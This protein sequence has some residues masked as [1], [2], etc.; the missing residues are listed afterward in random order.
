M[1]HRLEAWVTKRTTVETP[2]GHPAEPRL[3]LAGSDAKA[4]V[5]VLP[6]VI[7]A[8]ESLLQHAP[9]IYRWR[10]GRASSDGERWSALRAS[11]PY[12]WQHLTN[13]AYCLALA[14]WNEDEAGSAQF[15]EALVRWPKTLHQLAGGAEFRR[16]RYLFS[17]VMGLSWPEASA[18]VAPLTFEHMP[19]STPEQLFTVVVRGA[20][21][22]VLLL[23][24]GLLLFWTISDKQASDIGARTAMA[25][26][27]RMGGDDDR[28]GPLARGLSLRS[29]F[30][31]L[32]V[33]FEIA[34][35]R[36]SDGSYGAVLDRLVEVLDNM[37]ERRVVPGRVCTPSTLHGRDG[38]LLSF[39]AILACAVPDTGDDDLQ[40]TITALAAEEGILPGG[41]SALRNTLHELRHVSSSLEQP[42]PQLM[43]GIAMLA[44]G[45]DGTR[46]VARLGE[47]VNSAEATIEAARLQRLRDRP[48]DPAALDRI[49]L[50]VEAALLA[51]PAQVSFFEGVRIERSPR[52]DT[53]E[54]HEVAVEGVAKAQLVDPPMETPASGFEELLASRTRE[55][56][57]LRAWGAFTRR[58]RIQRNVGAKVEQEEFWREIAPLVEQV[59]PAPVLVISQNAEAR[60]LRRLV[61]EVAE[62]R[63]QLQ[64]ERR[65]RAERLG[66]YVATVAGV[67]VY[68]A[69]FPAGVAWLFSG[70]ALRSIRYSEFKASGDFVAIG[71]EPDVEL[72]GTLRLRFR[73][74]LE[75][76]LDPIFE[77]R[78]PDPDEEDDP[79]T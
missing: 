23:T 58:A 15:R 3:A 64:I 47:I 6:E 36:F 69:N 31:D 38:L 67:D 18:C 57:G 62:R 28:I 33:R 72:Q 5:N 14:V 44:P 60:A 8:W 54:W 26:L 39:V 49:R 16:R 21:D 68:G 56:A 70:R 63:P 50:A 59:G 4:Y 11:W 65:P 2:V 30:L 51:E 45:R 9:S 43:R 79:A 7:G 22:D 76:T 46:L 25:I 35:E 53:A 74:H 32:L 61:Y 27:Q 34:G 78:A 66:S 55:S 77:L 71:F 75:W 52:D 13:T 17:D 37:T 10:E 19:A 24:A 1:M 41:D 42:S 20:H 48:V 29:L 12:L 73:R 40:A